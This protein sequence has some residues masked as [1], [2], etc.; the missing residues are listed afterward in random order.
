MKRV[1]A[2]ID[3]GVNQFGGDR[4]PELIEELVN[5]SAVPESRIDESACRLL[6]EKFRLGLFENRRAEVDR[7]RK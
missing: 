6:R 1:R 2:A 5:N 7:A 3:V 4:S